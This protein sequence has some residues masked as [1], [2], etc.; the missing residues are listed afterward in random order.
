[1][2]PRGPFQSLPFCDSVILENPMA[3]RWSFSSTGHRSLKRLPT[4]LEAAEIHQPDTAPAARRGTNPGPRRVNPGAAAFAACRSAPA[5]GVPPPP[6]QPRTFSGAASPTSSC[7]SEGR[8]SP[9]PA[10][11]LRTVSPTA[12][13]LPG[14]SVLRSRDLQQAGKRQKTRQM[15]SVGDC[16][17]STTFSSKNKRE[18]KK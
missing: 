1:M 18:K 2:I 11:K 12:K 9:S 16:C 3:G 4:A 13:G 14:S 7:P 17:S 5:A 10:G 15:I 6:V 8:R